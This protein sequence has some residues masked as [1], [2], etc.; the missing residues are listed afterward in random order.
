MPPPGVLI[1]AGSLPAPSL[2][3]DNRLDFGKTGVL[4][5]AV[6]SNGVCGDLDSDARFQRRWLDV[7]RRL[8]LAHD[9]PQPRSLRRGAGAGGRHFAY[10]F[11]G[12]T[13]A[14]ADIF[15]KRKF[16]IVVE[17]LTTVVSAIYAVIVGVGWATPGN[18]LLFTFLVGAA[19]ALTVPACQSVVPQLVPKDD[20]PGAIAANSVGVNISRGLG[21]RRHSN[22]PTM[23]R[24]EI[25][26]IQKG[27][28]MPKPEVVT[29]PSAPP[30]A[31]VM[32][33][34][35][36]NDRARSFAAAPRSGRGSR[37][38]HRLRL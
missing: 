12:A 22:A 9:E 36:W 30:G 37:S 20:L 4:R 3:H 19:G 5:G 21:P 32:D 34:R 23:P 29:P 13:G 24:L 35:A 14:L 7:H 10:L 31:A 11:V 27:A 6:P 38:R 1:I 28:T 26:L 18:L 15:D 33:E 2:E 8:G 17:I 16:L 25:A